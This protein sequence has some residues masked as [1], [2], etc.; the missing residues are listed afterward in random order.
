M[1]ADVFEENYRGVT[2]IHLVLEQ[3]G[4]RDEPPEW[5]LHQDF[6]IALGFKREG[7]T[8]L[9][10]NEGYIEVARLQKRQDGRASRLEVRAE[11]LKDYLCARNMALYVTSYRSRVEV[12]E[13]AGHITWPNNPRVVEG[14]DRWVGGV[15]EIHEGGGVFGATTAVF[16]MAR[17]DVDPGEEVPNMNGFPSAENVV[18][19]SWTRKE[20]GRKL[21]RVRGEL[22]RNEWVEPGSQ[23]ARIR[24]DRVPPTIFFIT[25]AS[26]TRKSR[27]DLMG[28]G[29]WLWFRP[30]V[31]MALARRRGGGLHWYTRDTGGVKCSPDYDVHFG[32]N[33]LGECLTFS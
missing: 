33:K 5:H 2:G 24:E 13:D 31:I 25:D 19:S 30:E 14:G 8:W 15:T 17:T 16:H 6:V 11:H 4:N 9:A 12:V 26:G 32:V 7:D 21:Y 22:W 1:P 23:S 27:E 29:R 28:A 18:S 10:I 3:R 20:E